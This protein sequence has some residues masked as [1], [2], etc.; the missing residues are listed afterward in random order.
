MKKKY[1]TPKIH[2]EHIHVKPFMI[3]I[4]GV[5]TM[6][7]LESRFDDIEWEEEQEFFIDDVDF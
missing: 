3:A 5:G 4:S 1:I 7:A 6:N 2:I